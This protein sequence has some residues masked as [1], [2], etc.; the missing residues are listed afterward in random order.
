[1]FVL[2]DGAAFVMQWK[3]VVY[4][5][6]GE[7]I[8]FQIIPMMKGPDLVIFPNVN[9]WKSVE[10]IFSMDE[11][12]EI[13]F[14]LEGLKWKRKLKVIESEADPILRDGLPVTT[15]MLEMTKGYLE[16]AAMDLFDPQV[17]LTEAQVKEIYLKV[18]RKYANAVVGNITVPQSIVIPGSV[19]EQVVIPELQKNPRA[20]LHM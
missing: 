12:N 4:K 16:I 6:H 10:H 2:P 3:Q 7:N 18:E 17:D 20:I 8:S 1:M 15:G 9:R 13:I 14:Y 11:R 5:N 19:L